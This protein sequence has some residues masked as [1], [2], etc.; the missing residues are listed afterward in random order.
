MIKKKKG[1]K[2]VVGYIRVSTPRQADEGISLEEQAHLLRE[3]CNRKQL[4]LLTIEEDERTA[5]GADNHLH[6]PGLQSAIRQA[7]NL[8]VPILVPSVDRLARHLGILPDLFE[9]SIP[10]ISAADGRRIGKDMLFRLIQRAERERME[11]S[12]RAREGMAQAKVRGV[13]FGN[14]KNLEAAQRRG[15][16]S[17]IVRAEKKTMELADYFESIPEWEKM[18]LREL[19]D[20]LNSSGPLN[21]ISE[22][23]NERRAWTLG[24]IRKPLKLAKKEISLR[25]ELEADPPLVIEEFEMIPV[26]KD[27]KDVSAESEIDVIDDEDNIPDSVAYKDNPL[28]GQY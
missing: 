12:R 8:G 3:Y 25:R 26:A 1:L 11:I 14:A 27:I 9:A 28:F 17:N 22:R 13:K 21:L 7:N 2:K 23:R 18:T 10:V 5:G 4:H 24:S 15:A 16:I 19:T 20:T 6:R